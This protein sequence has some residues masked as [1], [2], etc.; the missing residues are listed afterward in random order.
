M[1]FRDLVKS[2]RSLRRFVNTDVPYEM[3]ELLIDA[4]RWAP[5]AGNRQPWYFVVVKNK[6]LISRLAL[7]AYGMNWLTTAPLIIVVCAVGRRSA[8]YYGKRGRELYC[9]QDTAAAIQNILLC[10][11]D[12][13]LGSC[14]IG[15]FSRLFAHKF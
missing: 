7:E 2:R 6:E 10:A 5:N 11:K 1:N 4:A 9:I 12:L 14:W 3:V 13:D 15:A 8:I